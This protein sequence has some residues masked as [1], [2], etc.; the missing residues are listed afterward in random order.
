MKKITT[1]WTWIRKHKYLFVTLLFLVIIVF[2]DANNL[3]RRLQHRTEIIELKSEIA[4]YQKQ[5]DQNTQRLEELNTNP[6]SMEKIAREKYRM[7]T[8][9]ED[10]FIFDE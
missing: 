2:F 3:L 8:E 10:V 7:H 1:V 9:N 6:Q 5:L 4:E